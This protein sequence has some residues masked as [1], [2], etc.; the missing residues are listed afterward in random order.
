[1]E[2]HLDVPLQMQPR[3]LSVVEI[4]LYSKYTQAGYQ[5]GRVVA[6]FEH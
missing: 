3:A 6:L 5:R 1:M 4:G 2:L